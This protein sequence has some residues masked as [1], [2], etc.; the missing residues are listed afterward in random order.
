MVNEQVFDAIAPKTEEVGVFG[1]GYTYSGHP[2]PA[3]VALETL[4]IYEEMDLI[5]HVKARSKTFLD[6]LHG[7]ADHPLVGETMGLGL[8]GAIELIAERKSIVSF[9]PA[10]TIGPYL[11]EMAQEQGLILRAMGDRVAFSPP[12][13]ISNAEI[14][15]MFQR[16]AEALERTSIAANSGSF[17]KN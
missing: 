11:T 1:H 15:E 13:I 10:G 3:A 12:L 2:V 7:F 17:N 9:E 8:V 5:S 16:F 6:R 4:K 14:D